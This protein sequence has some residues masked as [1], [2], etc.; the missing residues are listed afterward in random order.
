MLVIGSVW[1]WWWRN[2][3]GGW[4]ACGVIEGARS[5]C[6]RSGWRMR[7]MR[8]RG[9]EGRGCAPVSTRESGA[10]RVGGRPSC[11]TLR[12]VS[13]W[14]TPV[15]PSAASSTRVS[16]LRAGFAS[17]LLSSVATNPLTH[18]LLFQMLGS[19]RRG[20]TPKVSGRRERMQK[21]A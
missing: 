8:K 3:S 17:P 18:R 2:D 21:Y 7:G 6:W 13:P 9:E 5:F 16:V 1:W 4:S 10:A 20:C 12:K 15:H 11:C 14:R 19:T